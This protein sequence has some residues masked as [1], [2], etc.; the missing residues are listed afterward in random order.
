MSKNIN[1]PN[2]FSS[3]VNLLI[4]TAHEECKNKTSE[5]DVINFNK[6]TT[7]RLEKCDFSDPWP[8]SAIIT[9]VILGV[10]ALGLFFVSVKLFKDIKDLKGEN[11][12]L[13]NK[14][15]E[16]KTNVENYQLALQKKKTVSFQDLQDTTSQCSMNLNIEDSSALLLSNNK[17]QG[18]EELKA[19]Q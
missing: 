7:G 11:R 16:M 8:T 19:T 14:T 18:T 3:F 10:F 9:T 4:K 15:Q 13:K 6:R 1:K 5:S 2:V 12:E 17:P